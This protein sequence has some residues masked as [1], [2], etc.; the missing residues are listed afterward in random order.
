[1]SADDDVGPAA[2]LRDFMLRHPVLAQAL[3]SPDGLEVRVREGREAL[4]DRAP[5]I[6]AAATIDLDPAAFEPD[7]VARSLEAVAPRRCIVLH[8][9]LQRVADYRGLLGRCF[10]R[11]SVGGHLIVTVPHQ[12]LLERKWQPPSRIDPGHL[13]FYT[14]S[15]LLAEIEEAVDPSEFR[16]R[17]LADHDVGHDYAARIERPPAGGHEIVLAIE[18]IA[19]P[20][21]RDALG[22]D[23]TQTVD[24]LEPTRYV[25]LDPTPPPR[26]RTIAP[27]RRAIARILVLKLDHRGDFLMAR[28]AFGILRG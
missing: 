5:L 10:D 26:H 2:R 8:D 13:R 22:A 16:V 24:A 20:A 14:P 23:E 7:A 6:A 21:W 15:T 3:A 9:V 12:F 27:D 25:P 11:L 19:R 17:L 1:M 28:E 4:G 18:K